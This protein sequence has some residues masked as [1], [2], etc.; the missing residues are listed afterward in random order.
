MSGERCDVAVVGAGLVGPGPGLRAGLPGGERDGRR[1]RPSR[2][3]DR[4]RRGHPVA[5][6]QHRDRCRPCGRSCARPARTTRPCWPRMES[7]GVDVDG[8]GLRPLR[9]PLRRP[10]RDRGRVV[11]PLRRAWC[12]AARPARSPRSRPEEASSLFP[13]LGPVHRV[14]HAPGSARVDGRGMAAALRQAAA[15]R[16]VAFVTGAAHGVV[17]GAAGG[18]PRRG[19]R[20]RGAPERGVRRGGRRRRRLDGGGGRVARHA[21]ARRPDQ[22]ADRASRRRRGH[23]GV[24]DRA[25]AAHPLS[26]ALA[27]RAGG[28]RRHLRGRGR[29]LRQRDRGRA[30][31]SCCASASPWRRGSTAPTYLETRVGLRPT[32]ADDRAVVGRLPGWGNAWV[33]TGPRRQRPA[34]GALL[35]PGPGPRHGRRRPAGRRGAAAGLVRPRPFRLS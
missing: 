18:A 3:G 25:A 20:G 33:A 15:A 10:A 21:A 16:G 11:R 5:A 26:R 7:D 2:A 28:L 4:R 1:R 17:A 24:A 14:L 9:H 27:R 6:H 23:G 19:R 30:S 35:G 32:S 29:V 34:A 13:P 12:C 8:A 22:G 31:T